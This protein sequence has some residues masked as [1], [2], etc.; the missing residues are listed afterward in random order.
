MTVDLVHT[1]YSRVFL[2]ENRAGPANSPQYEGLWMAGALSWAQGDVTTVRIP[3]PDAYG[4]F[5]IAGRIPGEPGNPSIPITARYTMDLSDLLRLA[6][7][8]CEHDL[9]IHMGKCKDPKDFNSGWEKILILEEARVTNYGTG[10]LGAL[11]PSGRAAINEDVP[12]SGSDLYEVKQIRY[13]EQAKTAVYKEVLDVAVCDTKTCGLCGVVSDGCQIIFAL[14]TTTAGSPGSS[15]QIVW[16]D[17][18]GVTWSNSPISSMAANKN[19]N[20]IA[21]V[22]NNLVVVSN[23]EEALHYAPIADILAGTETWIKVTTGFVAGK[24]PNAIWSA[25]PTETWI[26]GDGGYIYFTSDP[27]SGVEVKDAGVVTTENLLSV[28]GTDDLHVSAVGANNAVLYT[29]N[30]GS[31]WS[32]ITGPSVG[33]QLNVI[34]MRSETEWWIGTNAGKLF[35][36][37]DTGDSFTEKTFPGSGSG[38]VHDIVFVTPSVGYLAHSNTTPS[39]RILRTISGGNSWYVTP[40]GTTTLPVNDK[41]EALATCGDPNV[42][43]GGGLGD[44]AVD[45]FLVKGA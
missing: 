4:Q 25:S 31:T 44:N 36:T 27:T 32:S 9:Q 45:G 18:G 42:V 17:D 26:V 38:I 6:R 5:S 15:G 30:G 29:E 43:F 28:H 1:D 22:G 20:A 11:D 33:V 39:G 14:T 3:S 24:G 13:S 21:C 19:G 35:Y 41:V 40:E 7:N 2:I 16:S 12:F 34:F 23:E 10:A 8:G 37:V